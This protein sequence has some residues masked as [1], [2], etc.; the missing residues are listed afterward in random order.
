MGRSVARLLLRS[1]RPLNAPGMERGG[2]HAERELD[3]KASRVTLR[4]RRDQRMLVLGPGRAK[5]QQ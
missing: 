2:V 5:I 4:P 3:R 1:A